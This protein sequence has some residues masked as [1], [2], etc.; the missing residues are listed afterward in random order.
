MA[1]C[2]NQGVGGIDGALPSG[3]GATQF[4]ALPEG[5]QVAQKKGKTPGS[6]DRSAGPDPHVKEA[7]KDPQ[8]APAALVGQ[9]GGGPVR[10]PR[11]GFVGILGAESMEGCFTAAVVLG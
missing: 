9:E 2:V 6:R 4:S 10:R 5:P 3:M 8:T 1:R 7:G 11:W